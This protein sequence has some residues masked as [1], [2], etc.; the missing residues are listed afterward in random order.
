MTQDNRL[1]VTIAG[2]VATVTLARPE[3]H[4]AIDIAMF[5]ALR[6]ARNGLRED[7]SVRAVVLCGEGPS[8][9]SGVDFPSFTTERG[10]DA[11]AAFERWA[12]EAGNLCQSVA[13]GWCEVPVPVIAAV[14]GV[15]FGGGFQIALG[16]DIR[17]CAPDARLAL[18]ETGF[19]LLPDMGA[20]RT[21]A[22]LVAIDVAKDL[23][24]S[25]RVVSGQEA[26]ALGLVTRLADDPL[27]AAL[28]L[29][30]DC[31]RRSPDAMR[32]AKRLFDA[33]RALDREAALALEERM[34]RMLM[35]TPNQ[36]EAVRAAT[37]HRTPDF[38]AP[39]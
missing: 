7:P 1:R 32:A 16:A 4:N 31:A 36:V 35:G 30:R 15:A 24:L 10:F 5:R 37:A 17:I 18:L 39:S 27:D 26:H 23:T 28:A 12:G 22:R 8:F 9:C 34:Q 11:E 29:A 13:E 21:L 25:G 19:G 33:S 6:D 38:V 2:H 3:R 20:T 14:R